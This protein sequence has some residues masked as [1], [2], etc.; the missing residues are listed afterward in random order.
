LH[1]ASLPKELRRRNLECSPEHD[2]DFLAILRRH[3]VENLFALGNPIEAWLSA[4]QWSVD[5]LAPRA[6]SG[7]LVPQAR[8]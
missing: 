2:S 3:P 7:K 6:F 4:A 1:A 8:L 5:S